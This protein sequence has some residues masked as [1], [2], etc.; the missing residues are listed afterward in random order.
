MELFSTVIHLRARQTIGR[1]GFAGRQVQAWFL[2]EV[3]RHDA[4]L[5]KQ[6]HEEDTPPLAEKFRPYTL[7]TLYKGP[8]S[9]WE[10]FE[11][12]WCWVRITSLTQDLS[13][14]LSE[15]I[16]P[17]LLPIARIGQVEFDIQRQKAE[18]LADPRV[19]TTSYASLMRQAMSSNETRL[20]F[21]F[22]SPTTFK[23][24]LKR[25]EIEK[26][27]P[28]PIPDYVFGNYQKHWSEFSGAAL[29]EELGAFIEE[30][31]V[32][33]EVKI[34]SERVQFS[35]NEPNRAATGF[36]GQ[37]KYKI[38]GSNHKSRFG[39]DW[40]HYSNILRMLAHYSSFCGTGHRT[41]IGL[42]QTQ[43]M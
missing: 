41:T 5:A 11:G 37:V 34:K 10:L 14:F 8:H 33:N 28:L 23:E 24:K 17:E 31:L 39:K 43:F 9:P 16:L 2:R 12:D 13:E 19:K 42:G 4:E 29:P 30:C 18:D 35:Y 7:S 27:I 40:E 22:T 3:G 32:I 21:D 15:K 1:Y 26:D 36:T 38:L 20:T 6:L 25:S